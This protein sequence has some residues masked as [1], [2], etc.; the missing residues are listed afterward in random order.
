MNAT[1]IIWAL[2][3]ILRKLKT[4]DIEIKELKI[5]NNKMIIKT[6][7]NNSIVDIIVNDDLINISKKQEEK[8]E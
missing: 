8:T 7:H 2:E 1:K 5:I 3:M 6:I 4:N